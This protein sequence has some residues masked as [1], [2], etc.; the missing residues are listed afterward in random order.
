MLIFF[1]TVSLVSCSSS[2]TTQTDETNGLCQSAP[3]GVGV[4]LELPLI[5]ISVLVDSD[6][7]NFKI[8]SKLNIDLFIFQLKPYL[9][10]DSP[11]NPIS[12]C[13]KVEVYNSAWKNS[14]QRFYVN[15]NN[16]DIFRIRVKTGKF[17]DF[18]FSK[19]RWKASSPGESDF[20]RYDYATNTLFINASNGQIEYFEIVAERSETQKE[21]NF[22]TYE[23]QNEKNGSFINS[24]K[25]LLAFAQDRVNTTRNLIYEKF[26]PANGGIVIIILIIG[27]L[28]LAISII[29]SRKDIS[30]GKII[31][32][33]VLLIL[34]I[35]YWL[36]VYMAQPMCWM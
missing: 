34:W 15:F 35:I 16:Q 7:L 19:D 33:C 36:T 30:C 23:L 32:I 2:G 12:S 6:G 3:F 10:F 5:P 26:G 21:N 20:I 28:F 18:D 24:G 25:Y 14:Y 22:C 8:Q 1:I 17:T 29:K 9:T 27:G 31:L 13:L 11:G 4:E